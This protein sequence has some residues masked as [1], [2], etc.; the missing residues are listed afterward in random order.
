MIVI[1][2]LSNEAH[3]FHSFSSAVDCYHLYVSGIYGLKQKIVL[4]ILMLITWKAL[5]L[6]SVYRFFS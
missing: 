5:Q 2:F 3:H 6:Q 4:M 1:R